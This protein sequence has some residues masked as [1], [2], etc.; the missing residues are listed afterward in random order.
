VLKKQEHW[1]R[2]SFSPCA[3]PQCATGEPLKK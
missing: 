3:F 2:G 1:K